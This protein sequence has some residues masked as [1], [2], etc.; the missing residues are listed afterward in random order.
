M[1]AHSFI[2]LRDLVLTPP[3]PAVVAA[4]VTAGVAYL[5]WVLAARLR[6]PSAPDGL[7]ASAGFV[8]AAAVVAAATHGLAL[9]QLSTTTVLRP[10][11]WGL[12]ALGLFAIARHGRRLTAASAREAEA[13]W[14]TPRL[15]R[16][17]AVVVSLTLLGLTA[18]ALGPPTD[19]DS[20][21]YHL[22]VPLDWLR[23]GGA[24][25]TPAW[26]HSRLIGISEGFNMLG[27]AA[28]TDGLGASMQVGGLVAAALAVRQLAA[29]PRDRLLAWLLV[30]ACPTM[31][32]LVPN[33]KPQ[34]L[35]AAATTIAAVVAVRR[36]SNFGPAD[37]LLVFG[38][39]AFAAA[40]KISFL[41]SVGYV[42]LLGLTAARRSG[43]LPEVV[44]V[45]AAAF[46]AILGPLL[47]RNY[48]YYG[49]PISPF[50]ERFRGHPDPAVVAFG[51]YLR[52]AGG[53]PTAGNLLRLP[54]D[55]LGTLD[56]GR[57]TAVL[58]LGALAVIP[59]TAVGGAPRLLVYAAGAAA[60]TSVVLGQVAPRFFLE[61]YLWAAA[62]LVAA[63]WTRAKTW[64]LRALD[65]QASATAT[66]ALF[67]AATLF[68][69]ALS[70][71]QRDR[72]M[73]RAAAGY[74]ESVWLDRLLPADAVVGAPGRFHALTP[75]PFVV[76]DTV[77]LHP[78]LHTDEVA[79]A[80]VLLG[81]GVCFVVANNGDDTYR[82]LGRRCGERLA[83]PE[84]F[85]LATRNPFNHSSYD[86]EVFDVRGCRR[87]LSPSAAAP[88]D[89]KP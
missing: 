27:L 12:A 74:A 37:A 40:S 83:A 89:G 45:G 85:T 82:R 77:L 84:V 26:F 8:L 29:T 66:V 81:A 39:A 10:L 15:E 63:P 1:T 52:T 60:A 58:G 33:Q 25:P 72:V 78:V 41:L 56:P 42:V 54:L 79:L 14:S 11:G 46:A 59:A 55:I 68:P 61:P 80:R 48:A 3:L 24:H 43:R 34:M 35:P 19:A 5:G 6:A 32:F 70:W 51:T 17:G 22:G 75:R 9:A 62:A 50:L 87:L 49:D 69:G 71:L 7:D 18:A 53:E 57:I 23:H 64:L 2:G 21:D 38:C 20:L 31:A 86:V 36:F 88:T 30:V 76:A 4:L 16:W 13:L 73:T 65:V 67:G 44:S 47:A 28:G